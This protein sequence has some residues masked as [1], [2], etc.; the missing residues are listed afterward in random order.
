MSYGQIERGRGIKSVTAREATPSELLAL[1]DAVQLSEDDAGLA[2]SKPQRRSARGKSDAAPVTR[3]GRSRRSPR[4]DDEDD[5]FESN[6]RR[7]KRG[8]S[9]IP[10]LPV[11]ARTMR[12]ESARAPATADREPRTDARGDRRPRDHRPPSAARPPAKTRSRPHGERNAHPDRQHG[13]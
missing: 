7:A 4:D 9:Q 11:P 5:G 1:L 12:A 8:K 13:Q 3:P 10:R 6:K 2:V